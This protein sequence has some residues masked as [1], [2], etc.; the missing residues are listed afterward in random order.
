LD[1]RAFRTS[2][3]IAAAVVLN[4]FALASETSAAPQAKPR[5]ATGPEVQ[6]RLVQPV[7]I[8]WAGNPLRPAVQHLA[9]A[10]QVAILIDR[11]VDPGQKLDLEVKGESFQSIL[12]AIV[13]QC[14]LGMSRLGPIVYLGPPS[15]AEQLKSTTAAFEQVVRK[16]PKA[17]QRKFLQTKAM[18]W[19]DLAVPREL[20]AELARQNGLK[21]AGLERVPHDLWAGAD[22]PPLSLIDRL[23][24]IA[25]QFDLTFKVAPNGSQIEL[26]PMTVSESDRSTG[27]R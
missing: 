15:V 11:R 23:S 16:L 14:G 3:P 18:A 22:L 6:R 13:R 27:M 26:V 2:W 24:L 4:V 25:M 1:N 21:I 20:L 12:Q 19:D 7:D 8:H 17:V 5:W 10:V 9:E